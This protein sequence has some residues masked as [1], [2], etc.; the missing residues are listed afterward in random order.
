MPIMFMRQRRDHVDR[1]GDVVLVKKFVEVKQVIRGYKCT[2]CP[3]EFTD[4]AKLKLHFETTP[5]ERPAAPCATCNPVGP[6]WDQVASC[7]KCAPV[8]EYLYEERESPETLL[9]E[10]A[11]M[12]GTCCGQEPCCGTWEEAVKRPGGLEERILRCL[13][14]PVL[15]R[16]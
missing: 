2:Y 9:K 6:P 14:L 7:H 13:G 10:L 16:K 3:K 8:F 11:L 12:F 1:V 4:Y 5:D 15:P